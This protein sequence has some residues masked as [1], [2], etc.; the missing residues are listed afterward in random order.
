MLSPGMLCHVALVRADVSEECITSI[1][2]MTRIGELGT[3]LAV[4]RQPKHAVKKYYVVRLLVTAN[5]VPSSLMLVT[6]MMEVIRSSETLFLTRATW[7]NI[8][9]DDILCN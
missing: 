5:M 9:E 1:I 2:R 3:M 4:T 6:L 7:H 8:P